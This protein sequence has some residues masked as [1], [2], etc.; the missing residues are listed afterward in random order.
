MSGSRVSTIP[1]PPLRLPEPLAADRTHSVLLRWLLTR[2][3]VLALLVGLEDD[4][5]GDVAYYARSLHV[6]FSGGTLHNTLIEYPLPVLLVLLPPFLIGGLNQIAFS[7]LFV[8]SMLAVDA[9]FT[10]L[11]WRVDGRRRGDAVNFWLWFGVCLG[12]LTYFRFDIVPAALAGAAVLAALRRPALC[13]GLTAAG[14]A[15][16]LWPAIMLPIFMLRRRDRRV[17]ASSFVATGAVFLVGCIALGGIDR[18]L[19]PLRWQSGRGL[20]IESVAATPLMAVRAFTPR[21]W[22]VGISKYKAFEIF[23]PSVPLYETI[24]TISTV[25]GLA[26]LAWLWI[27]ASRAAQPSV[28]TLGWLLFATALVV[29]ITNKTLSPQ[30]IVWLGGPLAGLLVRD[31]ADAAVRR[32]AGL[33]LLV[34]ALTQLVFPLLYPSLTRSSGWVLGPATATLVIRNGLLCYL[35]YFACRQCWLTSRP[36]LDDELDGLDGAKDAPAQPSLPAPPAQSLS[37]EA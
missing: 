12:P 3:L 23:G 28:A 24:S 5:T 14:A 34:A 19:S 2:A 33:L 1:L 25:L 35:T 20:Q 18:T 30:Y 22:E 29:T 16:K 31:P 13:A 32:A 36:S 10:A 6:L 21:T 4:V 7:I 15:L 11:L 37:N 27:R 8:T 9:A 17:V 26:V